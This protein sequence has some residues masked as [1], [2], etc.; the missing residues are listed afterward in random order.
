M[1]AGGE[2]VYNRRSSIGLS[3]STAPRSYDRSSD[4]ENTISSAPSL[5]RLQKPTS[6]VVMLTGFHSTTRLSAPAGALGHQKIVCAARRIRA[7]RQYRLK[8]GNLAIQRDWGWAPEYVEAMW[9]VLQRPRGDDFVIATG[10]AYSLTRQ[11]GSIDCWRNAW[12][13]DHRKAS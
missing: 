1:S 5:L 11:N 12:V 2:V 6:I 10:S 8:L 3:F 13:A 7:G 4:G 9:R